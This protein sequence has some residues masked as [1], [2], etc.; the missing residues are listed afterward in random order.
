M[1]A[2][3]KFRRQRPECQVLLAKK[4]LDKKWYTKKKKKSEWAKWKKWEKIHLSR[5]VKALISW[6]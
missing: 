1:R 2:A 4:S 6:H 5:R 3:T